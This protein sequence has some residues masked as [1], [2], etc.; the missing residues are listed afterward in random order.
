MYG[1][2]GIGSRS[3]G[4]SER[5]EKTCARPSTATSRQVALSRLVDPWKR[6]DKLPITPTSELQIWDGVSLPIATDLLNA[7]SVAIT[8]SVA[9]RWQRAGRFLAEHKLV[10]IASLGAIVATA[11]IVYVSTRGERSKYL[12]AVDDRP[13]MVG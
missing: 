13:A 12:A 10:T 1:D 8:R 6:S 7:P 2:P 4:A 5:L 9:S 11:G 3:G